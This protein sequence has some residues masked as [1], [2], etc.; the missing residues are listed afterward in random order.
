MKRAFSQFVIKS[1][2]EEQRLI[3]GVATTPTPDRMNDVV[4]PMGAAFSLPLPLL[5]QHRA[6]QPV[7][8]VE[9]AKVTKEGVSFKARIARS[10]T[11]G[12]LQNRLDEAWTSLKLGLVRGVSIGFA[13]IESA[14]KKDGGYRFIKWN[15]LELSLVTI[16]ANADASITSIKAAFGR[17]NSPGASGNPGKTVMKTFAEKIAELE[18]RI[19]PKEVRMKDIMNGAIEDGDRELNESEAEEYD[20]LA[21]DLKDLRVSLKRFRALDDAA[22][23]AKPVRAADSEEARAS[24]AGL[25]HAQVKAPAEKGLGFARLVSAYACAGGDPERALGIVKRRYANGPRDELAQMQTVL[26][27]QIEGGTTSDPSWA[28]PLVTPTNLLSEFVEYLRPMTIIGK[29]GTGNIPALRRI[30]FNVKFPAQTSGGLG[31]WVG[32]GKPKPLTRFDFSTVTLRWCKVANIAVLSEDLIRMSAPSAEL[33]VRNALAEALQARMDA[34]FVNP[35]ITEVVDV[36][37]PAITQGASTAVTSGV[38]ADAVRD[39]LNTLLTVFVDN[40]IPTATV[41]FIMKTAQ[42]L[43]LSLMRNTLGGREFPDITMNGGTLEGFPVITSQYVPDGVV[44]ACVASE[45]YLSDDGGVSIAL[46]REA[47]LEMADDPTNAIT[48]HGSPP[49]SVEATMVSMFQTNSVAIRA[50]RMINWRRR[51]LRAVAYLTGVG[52]GGEDVSPIVAI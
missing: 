38:D 34:D 50:E 15:W 39:D 14:M 20:A 36:R 41:V 40:D 44:V 6:D 16:P 26:K 2:D 3:E 13:V 27:A 46:S 48:D 22:A 29:F 17:Q 32:E 9:S 49:V 45:I 25:S 18:R 19:A 21:E 42:A 5:W 8:F 28:E 4:E 10:D 51:R 23:T 47:S 11:P 35:A 12:A 43:R 30:P 37:P 31:Y 52:W 33:V 24:R 1:V 7:G